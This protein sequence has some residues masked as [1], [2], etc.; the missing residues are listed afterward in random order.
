LLAAA[1]RTGKP[2]GWLAADAVAAKAASRRGYRCLC[3]GTDVALMRDALAGAITV[4]R[5]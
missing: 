3:L 4:A 1:E 5:G 2:L